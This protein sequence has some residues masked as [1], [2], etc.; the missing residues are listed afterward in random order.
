MDDTVILSTSRTGILTKL[1]LLKEFCNSHGMKV[2]VSKTKFMVI[3]GKEEDKSD[4]IVQDMCIK[5]CN[6]YVYLG[7]PFSADGLTS[8]AIKL[9][10][11]MK[12]G[13]VL[14]FVSF[15]QKNND[16]P[17][18]VKKKVFNAAVMSSIL[19]GC[20]S[21]LNGNIKP[22]EK[23]YNMCIKHLLGV[24]KNTTT[25]LCLVELGLPPL[26]ALIK[27]K[28]KIF[29]S[30]MQDDRR[31]ML[32][33]PFWYAFHLTTSTN[34]TTSR[35]I[36]EIITHQEDYINQAMNQLYDEINRSQSSRY[37]YYREINPY[38]HVHNI[39]TTHTNVNELKRISWTRLR[40]S[41]HNLAVETGRWNRRG[42]GRLPIE[43]RLCPCGQVQTERHV[44][45]E[46]ALSHELRTKYNVVTIRGL[47]SEYEN[48]KEVC[49]CIH[50]MLKIYK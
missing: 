18:N 46:C 14:K 32:D 16:V 22:M 42:R 4:L 31:N 41:A 50:E 40:V 21:W 20:E 48:Y 11:N 7:S 39:Y 37:A 10:A 6:H 45:E 8:S 29:F 2:N 47:V 19:Y 9:S 26:K 15:C 34:T 23:L 3:N 28:Q 25:N 13:Q 38:Y 43:E 44:V 49:E 1:G 33:D 36:K 12:M 27:Q 24:R 5:I 35:Y 30:S 17:F